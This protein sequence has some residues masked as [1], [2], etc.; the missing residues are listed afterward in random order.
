MCVYACICP[1]I[2]NVLGAVTLGAHSFKFDDE[3]ELLLRTFCEASN[4]ASMQSVVIRALRSFIHAELDA[5]KGIK[6]RYD[7]ILRC[8]V[9]EK[10]RLVS[11]TK[12]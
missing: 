12:K 10:I 9:G 1:R 5:N 4:D 3:T 11:D 8:R 2:P 7:E 6:E